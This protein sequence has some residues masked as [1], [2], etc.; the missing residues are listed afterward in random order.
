MFCQAGQ[1]K[2]M[3]KKEVEICD[4]C[5]NTVSESKCELCNIDICPSCQ[6]HYGIEAGDNVLVNF[7]CC[8][9]CFRIIQEID[10]SKE[11]KNYPDLKKQFIEIFKRLIQLEELE[12]KVKLKKEPTSTLITSPIF[13]P[14]N[15]YP[16]YPH[17]LKPYHQPNHHLFKKR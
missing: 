14:K 8:T 4:I 5:K 17:P 15:V 7:V 9:N 2:V 12:G 10:L 1:S 6:T 13:K 11:F 3:V 16:I